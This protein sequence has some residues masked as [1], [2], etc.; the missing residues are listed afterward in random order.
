MC[1][2]VC[3]RSCRKTQVCV[4]VCLF[5]Y[6]CLCEWL[7]LLCVCGWDRMLVMGMC[8]YFMCNSSVTNTTLLKVALEKKKVSK[9]MLDRINLV[10]W[11]C[12]D[13]S[14]SLSFLLLWIFYFQC[15]FS[16][17][18][19]CDYFVFHF[20]TLVAHDDIVFFCVIWHLSNH[21][22]VLPRVHHGWAVSVSVLCNTKHTLY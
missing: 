14:V 4:G 13:F 21:S 1:M 2:N 6:M 7:C 19:E 11:I 9:C 16:V 3:M 5:V 15:F 8:I 22:S 20:T 10:I 18:L 17:S 12:S